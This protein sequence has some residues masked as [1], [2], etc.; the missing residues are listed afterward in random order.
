MANRYELSDD[1]YEAA[2]TAFQA[3]IAR[4]PGQTAFANICNC[5]QGNISQLVRKRSLLPERLVLRAEAGTGI[6]RQHLRP[7]I[8]PLVVPLVSLP[9]E[10]SAVEAEALISDCDQGL[11]MK[12]GDTA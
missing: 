6:P 5:S 3:A 2:F 10:G 7:D 9:A 1:A 12:R 4:A 11:E 8:Y